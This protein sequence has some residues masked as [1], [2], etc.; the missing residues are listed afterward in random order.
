MDFKQLKSKLETA[1]TQP[2]PGEEAHLEL[3]PSGRL[4]TPNY[5]NQ[6]LNARKAAVL[7]LLEDFQS[8]PHLVV[9]QRTEYEGVHSGQISLPGGKKDKADVNASA[10]ALRETQEEI[11]VAEK[12]ILLLGALSEIYIPPSNFLV[13][14]FVGLA[15]TSLQLIP[16]E[17]E[18]KQIHRIAL[19][20]LLSPNS[21]Q[22]TEISFK[23]G[24]IIKTPA[25]VINDIVIWGATAM[26]VNELLRLLKN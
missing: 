18:V 13:Q 26:V 22:Q 4:T 10:T 1:L 19:S 2:L 6:F 21:I 15:Q 17:K 5:S 20:A 14:P 7:A 3:A 16:E 23:S 12:D 8:D 9:I 11:G 25:F 24:Y